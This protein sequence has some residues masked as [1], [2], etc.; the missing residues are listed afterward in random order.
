MRK[1]A[2][3]LVYS[4]GT[5]LLPTFVLIMLLLLSGCG[6][7]PSFTGSV[8][9]E[10]IEETALRLTTLEYDLSQFT[11]STEHYTIDSE[12][13]VVDG[14]KVWQVD[15]Y[16]WLVDYEN[17]P[18]DEISCKV[19]LTYGLEGDKWVVVESDVMPR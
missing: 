12:E 3:G 14:E 11:L 8:S 4:H 2:H 16:V 17:D 18:P 5:Y 10:D 19:E 9:R 7:T 1:A 15:V 13:L 6:T